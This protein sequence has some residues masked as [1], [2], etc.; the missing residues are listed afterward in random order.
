[1]KPY[2]SVVLLCASLG[3][4][5][6]RPQDNFVPEF[7]PDGTPIFRPISNDASRGQSRQIKFPDQA[8]SRTKQAFESLNSLK[9]NP[10]VQPP[11][12]YVRPEFDFSGSPLTFDDVKSESDRNRTPVFVESKQEETTGRPRLPVFI[13]L[14]TIFRTTEEF[15]NQDVDQENFISPGLVNAGVLPLASKDD[16]PDL[17]EFPPFKR[18]QGQKP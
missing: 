7:T 17:V 4:A 6:A 11:Q 16:N 10:S 14:D 1:M 2:M 18:L 3:I 5:I 12:Y 13:E 8:P 15:R 9:F